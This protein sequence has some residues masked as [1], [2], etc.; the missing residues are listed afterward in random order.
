MRFN[1]TSNIILDSNVVSLQVN[2]P[3]ITLYKQTLKDT[4]GK[5]IYLN[6]IDGFV[7]T[8]DQSFYIDICGTV[9]YSHIDS[10]KNALLNAWLTARPGL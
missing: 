2:I 5:E 1:Y 8:L 7:F 3:N 6:N 4:C 10:I 9:L